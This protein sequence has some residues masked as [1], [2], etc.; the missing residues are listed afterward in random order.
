MTEL[1]QRL[2]YWKESLP[3]LLRPGQAIN[4]A[5][6]PSTRDLNQ[7]ICLHFAYYGSLTAI[8]TIFFY[9]WISVV[10]GIGPQNPAHGRQILESSKVVAAAARN[11]IET[12]RIIKI[13]AASPQW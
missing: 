8:H 6:F 3:V 13:D 5:N 9:P 7:V 1:S 12:T 11:I 2:E 4:P 10:C